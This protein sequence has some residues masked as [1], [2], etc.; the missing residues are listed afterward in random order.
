MKN[1]IFFL[2]VGFFCISAAYSVN[3]TDVESVRQRTQGVSVELSASDKSVIEKFWSDALNQM[4]LSKSSQEMVDVRKQLVEQ[5]GGESLSY[6]STTYVAQAQSDIQTAFG[7]VQR[8]E[9]SQQRQMIKHNLMILTAELQSPQLA[10]L[11]L[12]RLDDSDDVVR[13]WAYKAVTQPAVIQQLTSDVTR[14]DKIIGNILSAFEPH[15][16]TLL[17]PEIQKMIVRFCSS[18]DL[19]SSRKILLT[20]ANRR[21]KAYKDWTVNDETADSD[22]LMAL[23]GVAQLHQNAEVKKDF[24]RAFAELYAL[25][26]QRYSKGRKTFSE[27]QTERLLTVIAQVDQTTLKQVMQITTNLIP[28]LRSNSDLEREYET[29]FGDRMRQGQL[30]AKFQFDYGKDDAGRPLT[31]PPELGPMPAKDAK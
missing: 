5:K 30:A 19:A 17:Y 2:L 16:A 13:Y 23:G 31:S 4:L 3:V 14:D 10:T 21:M 6:Y 11:A 18:F 15:A 24:G 8:L 9:D 22:L 1:T 27:E 20:I 12:P 26:I 25:V 7:D 28:L 29:L